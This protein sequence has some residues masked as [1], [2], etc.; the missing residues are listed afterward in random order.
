M[1]HCA[2]K[3]DRRQLVMGLTHS[4]VDRGSDTVRQVSITDVATRNAIE[5]V[6]VHVFGV[7][8]QALGQSRRGKQSVAHA[9]QVAMYLA[10]VTCGMSFTEVGRLF[11]RD[12]TTVAHACFQIESRRDDLLL[13]RALDLLSWAI[14]V[15]IQRSK[16]DDFLQ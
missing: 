10:H 9:R 14:P 13:D 1:Y 12:R 16:H 6:V 5:A 15:M 11:S 7:D 3:S 2:H 8:Q 4:C